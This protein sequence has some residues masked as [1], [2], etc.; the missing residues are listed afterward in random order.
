VRAV[1]QNIEKKSILLNQKYKEL[2]TGEICKTELQILHFKRH[3][4]KS[5]CTMI[6]ELQETKEQLSK[7]SNTFD[8]IY[9]TI[10]LFT[11]H[12]K[13]IDLIISILGILFVYGLVFSEFVLRK[14][15]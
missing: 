9:N 11:I 5:K 10:K 4:T 6:R 14:F 12:Q 1:K 2:R 15:I 3:Q 7:K 8:Y 13:T